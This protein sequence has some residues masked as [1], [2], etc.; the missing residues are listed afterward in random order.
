MDPSLQNIVVLLGV[1]F[2]LLTAAYR[3]GRVEAA[4]MTMEPGHEVAGQTTDPPYSLTMSKSNYSDGE[5]LTVTLSTNPGAVQFR[6]FLI[7]ARAGNG[8]TPLGSFKI[9]GS[10]AQTLKCTTDASAVSHTSNSN[11]TSVQVTWVA[12]RINMSDIQL[13]ATVVQTKLIFWM[14]VYGPTLNYTG[15]GAGQISA[16]SLSQLLLCSTVLL[17]ALFRL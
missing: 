15:S 14:P 9:S 12:P 16:P 6:G 11:K 5:E 4:C 17:P 1:L 7:Q 10:D 3:N 8:K 2:P 13:R